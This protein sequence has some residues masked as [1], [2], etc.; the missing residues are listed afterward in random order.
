VAVKSIVNGHGAVLATVNRTDTAESAPAGIEAGAVC[1][2]WT[3]VT[4]GVAVV[5]V[6][7]ALVAAR[8]PRLSKKTESL[9]PSPALM[10]PLPSPGSSDAVAWCSARNAVPLD[11]RLCI[12]G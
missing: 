4:P 9:A 11:E 2:G 10:T 6:A 5:I 1:A 12:A 8:T 7:T 3:S